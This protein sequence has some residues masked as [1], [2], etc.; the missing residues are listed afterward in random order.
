[1][2]YLVSSL[3]SLSLPVGAGSCVPLE[4]HAGGVIYTSNVSMGTPLQPFRV[5]P[6][7]GSM[8]LVVPSTLCKTPECEPHQKFEPK[9]SSSFRTTAAAM[10]LSY[11]SGQI[12]TIAGKDRMQVGSYSTDTADADL[13]TN[14]NALHN[15]GLSPFDGIMGLGKRKDTTKFGDSSLDQV[16]L[17]TSLNV[18]HF[19]MCFGSTKVQGAG[20][21]G[22]MLLGSDLEP[23]AI[24]SAG[25]Q[26]LTVVGEN[27]WVTPIA[28]AGVSG[29]PPL[30]PTTPPDDDGVPGP[31]RVIA[32]PDT[33]TS[34]LTFPTFLYSALLR[35]IEN[36]CAADNCIRTIA[37]QETCDGEI[38]AKLPSIQ[39]ELGGLNISLPPKIYMGEMEVREH[40][41]VNDR[42][43]GPFRYFGRSPGKR[44]VPLIAAMRQSSSQTNLGYMVILGMPFFRR[45][46]VKFDRDKGGMAIAELNEGSCDKC[47]G[48][49]TN[50]R[51]GDEGGKLSKKVKGSQVQADLALQPKSNRDALFDASGADEPRTAT[52]AGAAPM[53]VEHL[54]FPWWAVSPADRAPSG[55]GLRLF[56]WQDDEN[57]QQQHASAYRPLRDPHDEIPHH[58]FKGIV[59]ATRERKEPRWQLPA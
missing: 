23:S 42:Q 50:D 29:R 31:L 17:L 47:P 24:T 53:Q 11:G 28:R 7:T 40:H 27:M 49:P 25:F 1:M 8:N 21:G 5:V 43:L 59:L 34:L 14:A 39:F 13:I 33:G 30:P 12:Q 26:S 35:E 36:G 37:R 56:S 3:V 22:R 32:L 48:Q 58:P 46:A 44:C 38:F 4:I 6:D 52:T 51:G 9:D 2:L 10:P 15:Y 41:T 19:T 54:R 57:L 16:P 18:D 55:E 20:M 45:Y